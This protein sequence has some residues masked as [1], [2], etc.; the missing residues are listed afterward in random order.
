M[1][2]VFMVIQIRTVKS[3]NLLVLY[4]YSEQLPVHCVALGI[5]HVANGARRLKNT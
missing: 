1:C 5:I 3:I 2:S 4:V